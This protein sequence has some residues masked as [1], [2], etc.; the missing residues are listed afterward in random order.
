[1]ARP[2]MCATRP[3]GLGD[4]VFHTGILEQL[5]AWFARQCN[6]EWEHDH[7]ISIQSTD[8]PGW[9]VKIALSGTSVDN[10]PSTEIRRGGLS[11][12]RN[13]RGCIATLKTTH[14]MVAVT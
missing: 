4:R 10:K 2:F 7:G 1:V 8:N 9:W 3:V 11:W 14:S 12:T 13:R 5:Q 6:G